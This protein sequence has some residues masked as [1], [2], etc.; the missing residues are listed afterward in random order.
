MYRPDSLGRRY[1]SSGFVEVQTMTALFGLT[2]TLVY[3]LLLQQGATRCR[4]EH[5]S[6][7]FQI[8]QLTDF[9]EVQRKQMHPRSTLLIERLT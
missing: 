8:I 6:D 3:A 1:Q 2:N 9:L 4:L 5:A 7:G